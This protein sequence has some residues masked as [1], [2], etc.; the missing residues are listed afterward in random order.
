[1]A[2]PLE[3]HGSDTER[4]HTS[5]RH[6]PIQRAPAADFLENEPKPLTVCNPL[7]TLLHNSSR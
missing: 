4:G 5:D 6:T 3:Q 7:L 2:G 1:M